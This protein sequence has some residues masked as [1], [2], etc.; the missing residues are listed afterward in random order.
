MERYVGIDV[1][2]ATLEV[3]L[4]PEGTTNSYPQTIAGHRR[5]VKRLR[6]LQ[7][8]RIAVEGTGGYERTLV[9]ALQEA[10]LPVVVVNPR[11]VRSFAKALG[12]LAKTD[13]KDALVIA[14]YINTTTLPVTAIRS[15][16]VRALE[17]LVTRRRQVIHMLTEDTNRRDHVTPQTAASQQRIQQALQGEQE[18][19]EAQIDQ[20]IQADPAVV[21]LQDLLESTPGIGPVT[22]QMLIARLPELGTLSRRQIAALVGVAPTVHQ[23]GALAKRGMIQGG[24]RDVRDTLFMAAMS[25]IRFNPVIKPFYD[26]L[27]ANH[28]PHKVA[29]VAC[30]RKLLVILNAMVRDGVAWNPETATA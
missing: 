8:A 5:L 11:Q 23:S 25:A 30:V 12:I 6:D 18:T 3:G 20:L 16:N 13:T 26:R 2:K 24:R 19:L 29:M 21:L 15:A 22:A 28:K 17:A 4:Y 27:R 10:R 9:V 1:A 7:P 14:R